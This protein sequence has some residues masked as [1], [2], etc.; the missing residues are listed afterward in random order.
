MQ[1]LEVVRMGL[2]LMIVCAVA[3]LAL[4]FTATAT[5]PI[6]D[7][8]RERELQEGLAEALPGASDFELVEEWDGGSMYEGY[9]DDGTVGYVVSIE[10]SGYAG[11]I[12]VL[13]GIDMSGA[14]AAPIKI[15]E[16]T[17]TP[18][19]GSNI[20]LDWFREQFEDKTREDALAVN[21]D[22]DGLAG[23]TVSAQAVA[24]A[25]ADALGRWSTMMAGVATGQ[26]IADMDDGVYRGSGRGYGGNIVVEVEIVDGRLV[27]VDVLEHAETPSIGG[28]AIERVPPEMVEEQATE[29]EAVAGA[30]ATTWGV[31]EAVENA[32]FALGVEDAD[33]DL[34]EIPDGT[35][36]GEAMGYAGAI[37]VKVEVEDGELVGIRIVDSYEVHEYIADVYRL[38]PRK[39]LEEQRIDVDA[40]S[41]A[42]ET[43]MAIIEAV[44]LSLLQSDEMAEAPVN[45][46]DF[47]SVPDGVYRGRSEGYGGEITVE[48]EFAGGE[49][50]SIRVLDHKE[51]PDLA[52]PAIS[53]V[54]E[55]ILERQSIVV[56]AQSGATE[57]SEAIMRAI[58]DAARRAIAGE[59]PGFEEVDLSVIPDGSYRGSAEGYRGEVVVEVEF[60]GGRLIRVEIVEHEETPEIA[61]PAIDAVT[62]QI[63]EDQEIEVD[64]YS[65]ATATS[66]A[67]MEAVMEAVRAALDEVP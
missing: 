35:Y 4:A 29:V 59:E 47:S 43:T 54:T 56:D 39:M 1:K 10:R 31:I 27:R 41:G 23:A 42:T 20:E 32:L 52:D 55:D 60:S 34:S 67:I 13:V 28:P 14:V 40:Y 48:V 17:E 53:A 30:T 26:E 2:F 16:H 3:A 44:K 65:G 6:I 37:R 36:E 51:T 8:N 63:V 19:L 21:D 9:G 64:A 61:G 33:F 45:D 25:V 66:V 58:E 11:P 15:L 49:L 18:G 57:T 24:G 38:I 46:V 22:L 7:E 12:T 50:E 62:D 5:Q